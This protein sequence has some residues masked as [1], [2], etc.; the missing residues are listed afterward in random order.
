[1]LRFSSGEIHYINSRDEATIREYLQN[2]QDKLGVIDA[3][4]FPFYF[5]KDGKE[6]TRHFVFQQT[7]NDLSVFGR[8]IR[9]HMHKN[10]ITSISSNIE[11]ITVNTVPIIT[12]YG[13]LDIIRPNYIEISSYLKYK[14]LQIYIK[15]N[16][17]YLVHTIDVINMEFADRYMI[18]AHTGM[19]I[20]IFSLIYENLIFLTI[21]TF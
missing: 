11:N 12:Q 7:Y 17:E 6:F 21:V 19:V 4:H 3:Q 16:M 10:L 20:D 5:M 8:F 13:A 18:D 2:M 1:M 9:I 15:N 14:K